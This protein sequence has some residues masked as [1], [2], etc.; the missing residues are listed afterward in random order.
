MLLVVILLVAVIDAAVLLPRKRKW[1]C[2]S[3]CNNHCCDR[4]YMMCHGWCF[5]KGEGG[6]R[7]SKKSIQMRKWQIED[8]NKDKRNGRRKEEKKM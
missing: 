4:G 5:K 3:L 7:W 1:I 2:T 6:Q 8:K